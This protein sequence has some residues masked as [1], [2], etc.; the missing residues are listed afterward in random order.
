MG[1]LS[2][3]ISLF[4]V[5]RSTIRCRWQGESAENI[6]IGD[7][8]GVDA[9]L[10]DFLASPT[11]ALDREYKGWLDLADKAV[12]ATLARHLIALA[13][14]GGGWLIFGLREQAG[15]LHHEGKPCPDPK[16]YSQDALNSIVARYASPAFQCQL[17]KRIC[18]ECGGEHAFRVPGGHRI[19]I[20]CKRSGPR[21]RQR[22][23]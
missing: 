21:S 11:E 20:T 10:S 12:A 6:A 23:P 8:E 3:R 7:E 5:S 9:R 17:H 14:P 2:T 22:P 1:G 19:P 13:N 15:E 16:A 18:G 4:E